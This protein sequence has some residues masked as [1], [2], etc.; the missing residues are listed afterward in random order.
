M[1]TSERSGQIQALKNELAAT[2]ESVKNLFSAHSENDLLRSPAKGGWS[3]AECLEHMTLTSNSFLP[4]FAQARE[5]AVRESLHSS[6]PYSLDFVGSI[7]VK[8]LEPPVRFGAPAPPQFLPATPT[9]AKAALEAFLDS[10]N[11]V[12]KE[13]DQSEGISMVNVKVTSPA[14]SLIKYNLYSAY[15]IL[16]AHQRRHLAQAAKALP[17]T[18]P[19]RRN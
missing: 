1:I 17:Q 11:Q 3:A 4:T 2:S 6:A 19:L 9:S 14:N 8:I 7:F 13:L 15:R 12:V 5:K 16:A 10:Q 18:T